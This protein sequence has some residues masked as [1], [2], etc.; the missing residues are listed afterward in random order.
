MLESYGHGVAKRQRGEL[1]AMT[2]K[3][4]AAG[5]HKTARSQ[6][7]ELCKNSI[8][9][10]FA[11]CVQDMELQSKPVG[12]REHLTRRCFRGGS[13]GWVNEE[14]HD[15]YC[16]EQFVEPLQPLRRDLYARLGHARDIAARS[17]KA[18]NE[19]ELNRVA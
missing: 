14:R 18:G 2:N 6:L 13:V 3:K 19:T 9:I 5:D 7:S 12:G 16:G 8:E 1:F 4:G 15:A 11:A 17:A 10:A